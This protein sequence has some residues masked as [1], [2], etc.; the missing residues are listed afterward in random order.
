[1]RKFDALKSITDTKK[2][3]DL[4]FDLVQETQN[5]VKQEIFYFYKS[6]KYL[7]EYRQNILDRNL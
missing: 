2:F 5:E 3:S 4:I 6:D 7:L 1:M